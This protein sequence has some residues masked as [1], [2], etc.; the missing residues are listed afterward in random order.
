M[1]RGVRRG[2]LAFCVGCAAVAGAEEPLPVSPFP[3]RA[4]G[5]AAPETR[6]AASTAND[7]GASGEDTRSQPPLSEEDREL[8]QH[9][10]LLEMLDETGDLDVLLELAQEDR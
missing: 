6:S 7:G 5:A 4:E 3:S 10:E 2:A 8:V 9:L 1:M